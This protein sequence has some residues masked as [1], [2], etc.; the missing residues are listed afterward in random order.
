[1]NERGPGTWSLATRLELILAVLLAAFGPA[2]ANDQAGKADESVAK[3]AAKEPPP[4]VMKPFEVKEPPPKLCFGM[5]LS[6]WTNNITKSI[7]AVYVTRVKSES[8][9]ERAGIGL[10]TRILAIDGKPVEQMQPSF[11]H[12]TDLNR[13]F[14]NRKPGDRL[15]LT[16]IPTGGTAPV[17]VHLVN[18][19]R[20]Y[21]EF[22]F[23]M[24]H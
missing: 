10:Y 12:G 15:T 16:I 24:G 5:A 3:A 21:T 2:L 8:D 6:V 9:A 11:R 7:T 19:A 1:M 23:M 4:V 18:R 17:T 13:A 22:D 14:I 20:R